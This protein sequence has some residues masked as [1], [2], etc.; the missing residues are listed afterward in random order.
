M[1]HEKR[2][3]NKDPLNCEPRLKKDRDK[4]NRKANDNK[5]KSDTRSKK[6]KV[7]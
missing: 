4:H 1:C 5:V 6:K 2:Q 7:I 3:N